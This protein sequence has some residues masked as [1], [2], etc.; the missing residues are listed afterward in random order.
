MKGNVN[1]ELELPEGSKAHNI[2]YV[3]LLEKASDN[4]PVATEFGYKPEDD[5]IYK[6][7]RILER[8]REGQYLIKWKGYSEDDN[9]WEPEENL[10][11]NCSKKLR[12]FQKKQDWRRGRQFADQKSR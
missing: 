3:L 6:V 7:E 1:Y 9:T 10:L 12:E 4:T 5:N 11:P 8:N 2:F